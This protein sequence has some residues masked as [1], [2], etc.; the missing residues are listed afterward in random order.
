M[1]I[2]APTRR[3]Q[4][5][6]P[7][8]PNLGIQ[9]EY[10]RR[11]DTMIAEMQ[12]SIIY[13]LRAQYRENPPE[14]AQDT[15]SAADLF[16][17]MRRLGGRWQAKFDEMAP[18]LGKWFATSASARTDATMQAIFKRA[19]WT[20]KFQPTRTWNDVQQATIKAN[21]DLIKSIP[22]ECLTQVQG[23]TMRAV[24]EGRDLGYMTKALQDQFGVTFRRAAFIARDQNEKATSAVVRVRQTELGIVEAVWQHSSAGREPRPTHVANSGKTYEIAKG[25]FDPAVKKFIWP[26][27]E[28]NCRC[29]SRPVIPGLG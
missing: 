5:L 23:I 21:V 7:T 19:G 13:W 11:L 4:V 14:L 20:V 25:W 1:K 16:A 24:Q 27:T 6:A 29:S 12:R 9:L 28:P 26:G 22:S 17:A 10:Q 3:R 15:S 2:V 8:R 18:K